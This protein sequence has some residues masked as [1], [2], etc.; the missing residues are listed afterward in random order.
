MKIATTTTERFATSSMSSVPQELLDAV[1][2]HI[3]A[4]YISEAP[5]ESDGIDW[6]A[7]ENSAHEELDK[8]FGAVLVNKAFQWFK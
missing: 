2:L 8:Q 6:E 7:A 3:D 4:H 1:Q 5:I